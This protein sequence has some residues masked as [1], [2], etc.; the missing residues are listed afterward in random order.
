MPRIATVCWSWALLTSSA[1]LAHTRLGASIPAAGAEVA[2][3]PEIVLEFSEPVHVTAF[4]VQ[5]DAGVEQRTGEIPA[6]PA[7]AFAIPVTGAL[8]PGEYSV[9]WRAVSADTHI[10]SG[11]FSFVVVAD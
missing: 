1:V 10:V 9:S 8:A 3:P 2:S 5:T 6:G 4:A 7:K 11:E